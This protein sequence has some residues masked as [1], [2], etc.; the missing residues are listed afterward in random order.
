MAHGSQFLRTPNRS[1]PGITDSFCVEC[2]TFIGASPRPTLLQ[3]MEEAHS[4]PQDQGKAKPA[5]R[6]TS[7]A[8]KRS[9]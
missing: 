3:L 5:K 4:C 1:N 8:P 7:R 6:R 9:K 2:Q